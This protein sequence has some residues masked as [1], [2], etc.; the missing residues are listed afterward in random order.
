VSLALESAARLIV[1]DDRP[2]RRLAVALGLRVIGTLGILLESKQRGL[3]PALRPH[4]DALLAH[5]FRVS[6][7]L[8]QQVLRDAGEIAI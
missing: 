4:L 6:Q 2:A 7:Q 1:L 5:H 8:Y 3:L